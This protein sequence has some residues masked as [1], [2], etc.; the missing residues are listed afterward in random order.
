MIPTLESPLVRTLPGC[1]PVES[2]NLGDQSEFEAY[3][4]RTWDARM[5]V[6]KTLTA[7]SQ[8]KTQWSVP[9]YCEVCRKRMLLYMDW[10]FSDGQTPNYRE[11]LVCPGCYLNNRQRWMMQ[12]VKRALGAPGA[13]KNLYLFEQTTPFYRCALKQLPH[14]SVVGSEY[15]GFQAQP[16][17][18]V[19]GIRHEDAMNLSF[20][21]ASLDLIVSND[22]FE[23]VPDYARAFS[24]AARVLRT[25]GKLLFSIPFYAN[26]AATVPRAR[27]EGATLKILLPEQHHGPCL[28][29]HDFGWDL[30]PACRQAGFPRVYLQAYYS[31]DYGY[32]GNGCQFAFVAEK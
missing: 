5:Q 11:R 28:V 25:N 29:F 26:Q 24:E 2:E 8:G 9:G 15:L 13:A 27:L 3:L 32:W 30:L 17:T 4:R 20:G 14:A 7:F 16:G 31:L 6:E 12:Y 1:A 21:D 10:N 23:H 18:V 22:V 19:N